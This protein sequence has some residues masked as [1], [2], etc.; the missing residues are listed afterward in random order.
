MD[1]DSVDNKD[2]PLLDTT[3]RLLTWN[4]LWRFD[5]WHARAPLILE[6]LKAVNADILALQ[7]QGP[8]LI[9]IDHSLSIVSC[10]KV[11]LT[12]SSPA[13]DESLIIS[14]RFSALGPVP[15]RTS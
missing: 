2:E 1:H 7:N 10:W 14:L 13:S 8:R 6:T 9:D 3:V 15:R 4:I 12:R 5:R 11:P